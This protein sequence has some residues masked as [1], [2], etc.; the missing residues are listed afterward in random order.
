MAL[1]DTW[2]KY[3]N[4]YI[5]LEDPT[6][7]G[8]HYLPD[9]I[10]F[11]SLPHWLCSSHTGYLAF[12]WTLGMFMALHILFPLPG[13]VLCLSSLYLNVTLQGF[14]WPNSKIAATTLI[15][16]NFLNLLL[17]YPSKKARSIWE[18]KLFAYFVLWCN[19][20]PWNSIWYIAD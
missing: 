14:P 6:W 5:D 2:S 13:M 20:N 10:F 1:C 18:G 17:A 4:Y 16:P 8:P 9:L 7:S 15:F 3:Q 19:S 11:Y 12:P